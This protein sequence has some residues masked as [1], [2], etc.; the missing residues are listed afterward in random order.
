MRREGWHH[1]ITIQ[2]LGE[3]DGLAERALKGELA[4]VLRESFCVNKAYL[5]RV[6]YGPSNTSSVAL[7][8]VANAEPP[9]RLLRELGSVFRRMFSD[10]Q[11]LDILVVDREQEVR[12]A[13]VCQPFFAANRT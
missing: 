8:L 4:P 2:F 3:Q 1:A 10:S 13:R 5:A 6:E 9:E 12:L 7:C 11:H